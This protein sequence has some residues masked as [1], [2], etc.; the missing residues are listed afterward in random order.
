MRNAI[1][2][3]SGGLDSTVTAYYVKNRF[4]GKLRLL[5]FN[6][7][8]RALKEELYCV[9]KL[10][11][12]LDAELKII[13]L[14]W[15]GELSPALLNKKIKL[16][17]TK[18]NDLKNVNKLK[19]EISKW[20][21]PCRNSIFTLSALAYAESLFIKKNEINDVYLGIQS[22]GRVPMKDTTK[23]FLDIMNM[24]VKVSNLFDKFKVKAPLL[25]FDKDEIVKLG[26]KLKIPFEYT[27]SCYVSSGFKNNI[28]VHCGKCLNCV[29]RKK[30][31]YW[32][33]VKD[34]SIYLK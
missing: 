32:A 28:P 26:F 15:L 8:Q 27:Y 1:V 3:C 5:F 2:I 17:V 29:L 19:K 18:E 22:E 21:V 7:G 9:K 6:Y 14:G 13:D 11:K 24:N 10:S 25:N 23:E 12:L 30:A 4:K 31:F 33:N 20:W 34:K 16:P